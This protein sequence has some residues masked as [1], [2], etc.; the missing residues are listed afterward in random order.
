MA[1]IPELNNEEIVA[2]TWSDKVAHD[3]NMKQILVEFWLR[4]LINPKLLKLF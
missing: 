2:G 3:Q 1:R 4:G